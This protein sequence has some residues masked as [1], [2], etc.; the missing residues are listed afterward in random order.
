MQSFCNTLQMSL[1]VMCNSSNWQ[2]Y[3]ITRKQLNKVKN[4]GR[5]YLPV[6]THVWY[7]WNSK[8]L[9]LPPKVSLQ[10][11]TEGRISVFSSYIH[12]E[13][14][15]QLSPILKSMTKNLTLQN[16]MKEQTRIV[17]TPCVIVIYG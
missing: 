14:Q 8:K 6:R 1:I 13:G 11:I 17:S 2:Q 10:Q 4:V 15:M 9:M 3:R 16:F 5:K 7:V 12:L